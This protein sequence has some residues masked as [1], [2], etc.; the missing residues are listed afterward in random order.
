MFT[1]FGETIIRLQPGVTDDP[2]T[3]APSA[4]W[5]HPVRTE[6]TGCVVYPYGAVGNESVDIGRPE[7][8]QQALT[9]L[10]PPGVELDPTDRVEYRGN[11]FDVVGFS[12]QYVNPFT[13]WSPGG[14]ATI[15]RHGG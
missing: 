1:P 6:I 8:T 14:Q 12:F 9:V 7:M 15:K 2:Y 3:G 11:E 10:I 5:N 13:G 4:D